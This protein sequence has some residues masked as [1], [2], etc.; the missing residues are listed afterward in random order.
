MRKYKDYIG[1]GFC[2][3]HTNQKL[4]PGY[5]NC[6]KC[7]DKRNKLKNLGV[8]PSHPSIIKNNGRCYK[9]YEKFKLKKERLKN[10]DLCYRHPKERLINNSDSCLRCIESGKSR[11][12]ERKL[13]KKCTTH[14]NTLAVPNKTLCQKCLDYGINRTKEIKRKVI[15]SYGE[16]CQ[17]CGEKESDFLTIDHVKNNGTQHRKEIGIIRGGSPMWDWIL[18]NNCPKDDFALLCFNCNLGRKL[19]ICPHKRNLVT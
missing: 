6:Q 15:E 18:K 7:F 19:N 17:C 14:K 10:M 8:C 2:R 9:C 16:K 13:N 1:L 12:N 4:V 11:Y 5:K 3:S